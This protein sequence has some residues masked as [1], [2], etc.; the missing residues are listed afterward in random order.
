[1]KITISEVEQAFTKTGA[2]YVKIKGVTTE[3]RE[4]TKSV[5]DNLAD[6]WELLTE[7]ALLDFKMQKSGQFWNVV[8]ITPAEMPPPQEPQIPTSHPDE[9][10]IEKFAPQEIGLWWK[11]LGARISDGALERDWPKSHIRIK[12]YY[13]KKMSEVT[14]V[15]FK[16]P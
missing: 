15:P 13:Y 3:G 11:E 4:L 6:K 12:Q 9:P 8:D 16:E 14:G 2:E 5:F 1:M 7:G 10:H